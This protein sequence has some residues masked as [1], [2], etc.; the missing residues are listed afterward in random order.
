MRKCSRTVTILVMLNL[1]AIIFMVPF[2]SMVAAD[3]PKRGPTREGLED[4][5][6]VPYDIE[7]KK[8]REPA[9]AEYKGKAYVAWITKITNTNPDL[10]GSENG[11]LKA[12]VLF[13]RSFD[14]RD[15]NL[16]I[17]E[18]VLLN[19]NST[20][21]L[22]HGNHVPYLITYKDLLYIFW[23][24]ND[25]GQ[26]P[27]G[28]G[29]GTD[30][31]Y[32][33]FD[34]SNWSIS[35]TMVSQESPDQG[36]D[37]DPHALIYNEMLYLVWTKTI[38][39]NRSVYSKIM[40]RS[41][42]GEFWGRAVDISPTMTSIVH[43][44]PRLALYGTKVYAT[45]HT[46]DI[47]SN[48]ISVMCNSFD[49]TKWGTAETIFQAVEPISNFL[50]TPNMAAFDNPATGREELY[51]VWQTFDEGAVARNMGDFDIIARVF[52]GT[53]W[54]DIFEITSPT[55]S[56][57]DYCPQVLVHGGKVYVFWETFDE[58]TADGR[59]KDIVMKTFDGYSWSG[60]Q[61]LS[62]PGDRDYWPPNGSH[63]LGDDEQ[64]RAGIY[65]NKIGLVWRSFDNVT[66]RDG[67]RDIMFR[68][69][70]D[71]D[72]DGD[73]YLDGDD[74]FPLDEDEWLDSDKDDCGDNMDVR[75]LDPAYC[76]AEDID[77]SASPFSWM[78]CLVFILIIILVSA[79]MYRVERASKKTM[80]AKIGYDLG[81]RE[82]GTTKRTQISKKKGKRGKKR[83]PLSGEMKAK[84]K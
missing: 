22:G 49:G 1:V 37:N 13:V 46:R 17:D 64:I 70:T 44:M 41:Y 58:G 30:I 72:N 63:N 43:E 4:F 57:A 67:S 24:S 8:Y 81:F 60:V 31:L 12:R 82:D 79:I 15:G 73:G 54:G 7:M 52:D 51:A 69:V 84:V 28:M 48:N 59:D 53:S 75:P 55:D 11:T 29:W 14:D 20:D 45:W 6:D 9:F 65:N 26:K 10:P 5:I 27:P 21:T 50:S 36:N 78:V 80:K 35:A 74:A 32:K 2:G 3:L 34:G 23:N 76:T 25:Q 18:H 71:Y 66:G 40:A 38:E 47:V 68:Y 56:G 39:D 61:L 77:D 42:D 83:P 19:P 16:K 33:T 62:R